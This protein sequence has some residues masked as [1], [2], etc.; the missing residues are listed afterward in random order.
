MDG[1]NLTTLLTKMGK[2]EPNPKDS[3]FSISSKSCPKS[4]GCIADMS[5]SETHRERKDS[6]SLKEAQLQLSKEYLSDKVFIASHE[7]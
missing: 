4:Y 1:D 5:N 2:R 6:L 3:L 7:L